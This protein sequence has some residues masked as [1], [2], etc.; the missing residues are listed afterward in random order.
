MDGG[1]GYFGAASYTIIHLT[2]NAAKP[3]FF[4]LFP[5]KYL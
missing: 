4:G 3:H 5:A 2:K 1:G